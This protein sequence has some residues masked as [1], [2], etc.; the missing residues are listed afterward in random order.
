MAEVDL[1]R[2]SAAYEYRVGAGDVA[3]ATAAA[4]AAGLGPGDLAVDVGGGTGRHS[5]VF[6]GAGAS[7]IVLDPSPEMAGAVGGSVARAVIGLGERMPLV[8]RC[9]ALVYFHMSIHH[10]DADAMLAESVRVVA[11]GR[12]VW[13]W[14]LAA[15]HHRASFLAR[16]FPSVGLIDEERFP[17]PEA[18]A[19]RLERLGMVGVTVG[20]AREQVVRTAGSWEDAVRAGFVSTLHLVGRDE[21]ER[22]LARFRR[23]HPDPA[24]EIAYA[25]DYRSVYGASPG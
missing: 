8:D 22:G 5:S 3:H 4:A 19:G 18:L 15:H 21:I 14:T 24:M 23:A 1:G 6:V 25:L 10:G 20:G 7:A 11:P 13:V 12:T 17:E 2:L 16:W 9:A